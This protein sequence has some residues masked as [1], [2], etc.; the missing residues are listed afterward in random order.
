M[1]VLERIQRKDEAR[2][3]FDLRANWSQN[4]MIKLANAGRLLASGLEDVLGLGAKKLTKLPG[5][6]FRINSRPSPT[7]NTV[8]SFQSVPTAMPT[9]A[10]ANLPSMGSFNPEI[11][12][13]GGG[14]MSPLLSSA[15]T[16]LMNPVSAIEGSAP[17]LAETI[18]STA[19]QLTNPSMPSMGKFR[20]RSKPSWLGR[21]KGWAIPSGVGVGG[22]GG[23]A[24]IAANTPD[25][26]KQFEQNYSTLQG[27]DKSLGDL[28][29]R[30]RGGSETSNPLL[31]GNWLTGRT[32]ISGQS[33]RDK[34]V[35]ELERRRKGFDYTGLDL[36]GGGLF[37]TSPTE[38]LR[39]TRLAASKFSGDPAQRTRIGGAYNNLFGGTTTTP[40]QERLKAFI[41]QYG[42]TDGAVKAPPPTSPAPT[43]SPP[44]TNFPYFRSRPTSGPILY[45]TL[46]NTPKKDYSWATP[47]ALTGM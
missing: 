47:Q 32:P 8:S 28:I 36:G 33:D 23:Y 16:P 29:E 26:A 18:S 31:G 10:M 4:A 15:R 30:V 22:L 1:N 7:A 6:R 35:S 39:K 5:A 45:P 3:L 19:K 34:I 20:P 27:A 38:A 43:Q 25:Y 14:G 17:G 42:L 46:D 21:N 9:N 12:G 11:I 41:D 44:T 13:M 24:G 37:G 2:K 40:D